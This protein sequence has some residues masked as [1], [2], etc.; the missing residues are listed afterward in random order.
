MSDYPPPKFTR[1]FSNYLFHVTTYK[2]ESF[3]KW[4]GM[5]KQRN[6]LTNLHIY[7]Y[8][9]TNIIVIKGYLNPTTVVDLAV[10]GTLKDT[11]LAGHFL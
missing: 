1:Y 5:R 7:V 10:G 9:M 4:V 2:L 6:V 11:K 3:A 8:E